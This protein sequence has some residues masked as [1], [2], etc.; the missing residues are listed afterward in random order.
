MTKSIPELPSSLQKVAVFPED[1]RYDEVRSNDYRVGQPKVIILVETERQVI[2]TINY[3]AKVRESEGNNFPLSI[4]SGGHGLSATSVNDGEIILDLSK[5]NQIEIVDEEQG[6]VKIQSGAIW[7]EVAK[8]LTPHHLVLS[9]GDHGDTG[10]GGLAVSGGMG[11]ILRS[12]GLTIDKVLGVTIITADGKKHWVD[13][14][15]EPELFWAIRGGGGQFG[16][17]ID[18]LFQADRV[19]SKSEDFAVPIIVQDIKYSVTDLPDFLQ[20]WHKW[21]NQASIKLSS[22]LLLNRG[23]EEGAIVVQGK[24]FWYGAESPE[25]NTVLKRAKELAPIAEEHSTPMD[26]SDFVKPE[27]APLEGK[28]TAYGKNTLVKEIP[29]AIAGKIE[30]LLDYPFVYGVELRSLGGAVN[31]RSANFNAWP[32]RNAEILIAYWVNSQY[33]NESNKLF[34]PLLDYGQGIYGSY[35]SDKRMEETNRLW[36]SGIA[37]KLRKLNKKYDPDNLFTQ[38]RKL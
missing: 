20:E 16:V 31:D 8:K 3:T 29:S 2:D 25:A 27:N 10:V 5:L 33:A 38:N 6:L 11:I 1:S 30:E 17:V 4:K 34:Q 15:H 18:F 37:E 35:S 12:F 14:K 21:F 28:N 9:S 26:Y 36:P 7:G 19:A 23:A 32:T 22:I 24:N 13:D